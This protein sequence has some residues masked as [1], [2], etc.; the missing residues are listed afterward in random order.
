MRCV[1]GARQ[2][3]SADGTPQQNLQFLDNLQGLDRSLLVTST[4]DSAVAGTEDSRGPGLESMQVGGQ[5]FVLES[6]LPDLVA[7]VEELIAEATAQRG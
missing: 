4:I 3:V 6:K 2:R 5:M 7:T 1:R